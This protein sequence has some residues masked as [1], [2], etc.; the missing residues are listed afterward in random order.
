MVD[1]ENINMK[2]ILSGVAEAIRQ[3]DTLKEKMDS[4]RNGGKSNINFDDA[5]KSFNTF[6]NSYSR[7]ISSMTKQAEGLFQSFQ[8]TGDIKYFDQ[9][10]TMIPQIQQLS[11]EQELFNKSLSNTS[12]SIKILGADWKKH[13]AWLMTGI[14]TASAIGGAYAAIGDITKLDEEFQQLKTVLPQA[15]E[16]QATFNQAM[17]DSFNLAEKYGTKIEDVVNSLRLMG[18]QY[19]E[20]SQAEQMAQ[21]ALKLSVADNFSPEVATKAIES[22]VGSYQKQGEAVSFA[23]KAMDSIT[24]VSHTS[25]ISAND[26][27][28]ALMRSAAAAHTVGI[29][30]DELNALIAVTSRNSGLS[31]EDIGN[32]WKS[33]ANSI[34]SSKAIESLKEFGI[35][36]YK[37]GEDGQKE[38]RKVTDVLLDVGIKAKTSNQNVEELF[39]NLAGGKWQ[40]SKL[41]AFLGSPDEYLKV[42]GNSINSSGFTDKQLAIQ[43]DTIKRKAQTLKASF[44]ELLMTGGG[45]SGFN[46][47]LKSILDTLSQIIKGL[48]N[49]NPV[50]W[51]TIG[52]I[53]K[54]A[55]AFVALRTAVNFATASYELLKTAVITT[56]G[57]QQT[58]NTVTLANPWGAFAK[59]ITLAAMALGTYAYFSG[60]A[61]AA[62]EQANQAA[63]NAI[64]AKASEVEMMK[65]QTSYMETLGSTYVGLQQALI[66]VGDD[67]TK[68]AEIKKTMGTVTEQ[69]TQ[70]VGKEA[71]DRI[72]ASD[73]IMKSITQEQQVHNEKTNQMQQELDT[74]RQTQVKLAN[75]TISMCNE[76]IGAINQ[77]AEAFDKAA[78]AIGK[79]LGRIDEAM[80]K[81]YRSKAAYFT[82]MANGMDA[83][84]NAIPGENYIGNIEPV[85]EG[86]G[87]QYR[88]IA[89]E[90]NAKAEE[91]KQ[92]AI[93]VTAE[94]GRAALGTIYTPGSYNTTPFSTGEV[95]DDETGGKK[96]RNSGNGGSGARYAPDREDQIAK[97]WSNHDVNHLLSE[98]KISA[99]KY[100]EALAKL[101][102]Q[103][104]LTGETAELDAL[105]FQVM[106]N[107]TV[108]LATETETLTKKRDE[109]Q[110]KSDVII[111]N[112]QEMQDAL[113]EQKLSWDDLTKDE[114]K[115]FVHAYLGDTADQK[116]AISYLEDV[117]KLTVKIADN[118]KQ[119]TSISNDIKKDE[120]S[121]L[122]NAYNR[123][124]KSIGLDEQLQLYKLS[125]NA[126]DEQKRMIELNANVLK[127]TEAERRLKEVKE[128][129]HSAE[130][131][132]QQEVVV[133]ELR[134]K[135][136]DLKDVWK[137]F[138]EE[139]YDALD[140]ILIQGESIGKVFKDLWKQ[141]ASEA[142]HRIVTG[143]SSGEGGLLGTVLNLFGHNAEGS[144]GD[145]EE[146]TWIREGNKKEAVIPMENQSRGIPLWLE[147]GKQMGLIKNGEGVVPNLRNPDLAKQATVNVQIQ[148]QQEHIA[149]LEKQTNVL[150]GIFKYMSENQNNSGTTIA[151]PIVVNK[152][153]DMDEFSNMLYKCKHFGYISGFG[154]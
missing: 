71:A 21:T 76:R 141:L 120:K 91:I 77:E 81:Y 132:K 1:G 125:P 25:Q 119:S 75:D 89:D 106:T 78:D 138:G 14:G 135:V 30:F 27:A 96:K 136:L 134:K 7:N 116:L 61:T 144:I 46:N 3:V 102:V 62:Q 35:E 111:A 15:E 20:L 43:M 39:R 49:I 115:D 127:L 90:A 2:F 152:S 79:A 45:E 103:Q 72:L 151:Q 121:S 95:P 86:V 112:S 142:L 42:L 4:V 94:K 123:N 66:Q 18:R 100:Q 8:K 40:V 153:M 87:N 5:N 32:M 113:A 68:A 114:K 56:T 70:I 10:K 118:N 154:R 51:S 55:A 83:E 28:E 69:L 47:S 12:N 64:T 36:S 110:Q 107:R 128:G 88:E 33:V 24:K 65:Q 104:D 17:K 63:N 50:V 73:D 84:G 57:A 130:E 19:K 147:T 52:G 150:V 38:F 139:A 85:G 23:E 13:I 59:L 41:S 48:N 92:N 29:S 26:L 140:K 117:D 60:E 149:E 101:H 53:T 93:N 129:D 37:V 98:G 67:E 22:I 9:Y 31:G 126:T 137:K 80:F 124:M 44:E 143:K 99:D 146:L 131:L 97:L 6:A 74:L 133:E 122:G 58:L 11:R 145:K 105:K 34:H 54:F 108:E 148:Q 109:Y 82:D 16:N